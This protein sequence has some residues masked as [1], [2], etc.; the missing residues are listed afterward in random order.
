MGCEHFVLLE[1]ENGLTWTYSTP[2]YQVLTRALSD[3]ANKTKFKLLCA[4]VHLY[5][6]LLSLLSPKQVS[7]VTEDDI[8][9]K[10]EFETLRKKYP[11][12]FDVVYVLDQPGDNWQGEA[13]LL[14]K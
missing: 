7:N 1:G 3:K 13:N 12:N 6:L 4:C 5:F 14:E 9:L 11:G 10:A 8:L 2:L